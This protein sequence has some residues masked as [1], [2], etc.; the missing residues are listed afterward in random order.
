M[1]NAHKKMSSLTKIKERYEERLEE[2]LKEQKKT[3][4][5]K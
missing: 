3:R 5:D 1:F 2:L 4:K